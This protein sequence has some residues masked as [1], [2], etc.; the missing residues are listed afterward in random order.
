MIQLMVLIVLTLF[1]ALFSMTETSYI[2][3]N[4]V[5]ISRHGKGR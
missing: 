1:G 3:L 5:K 2:S 4:D